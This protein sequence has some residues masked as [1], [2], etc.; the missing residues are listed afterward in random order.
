MIGNNHKDVVSERRY[1]RIINDSDSE[2]SFAAA[3]T[4]LTIASVG[5]FSFNLY[6]LARE[7][8]S[9]LT[10]PLKK[11]NKRAVINYSVND[12]NL[13]RKLS[14]DSDN[15]L[16]KLNRKKGIN[17]RYGLLNVEQENSVMVL[18]RIE[19]EGEIYVHEKFGYGDKSPYFDYVPVS[20]DERKSIDDYLKQINPNLELTQE[21]KL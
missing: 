18:G 6:F 1:E 5:L 9:K 4:F 21:I 2:I 20:G 11:G 7:K 15:Y 13:V 3:L 14:I 19:K 8:L 17:E 12:S 16:F 10:H